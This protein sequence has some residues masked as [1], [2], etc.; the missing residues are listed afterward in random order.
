MHSFNPTPTPLLRTSL[1]LILRALSLLSTT[2]IPTSHLTSIFIAFK[3][4]DSLT[5][6]E[7]LCEN[8]VYLDRALVLAHVLVSTEDWV[9]VHQALN[10]EKVLPIS[11]EIVE[12]SGESG[13]SD[14]IQGNGQSP[15]TKVEEIEFETCTPKSDEG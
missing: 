4:P 1:T 5:L 13:K 8:Q 14:E 6:T 7:F 12:K 15:P 11:E 9:S 3:H 10:R 2:H